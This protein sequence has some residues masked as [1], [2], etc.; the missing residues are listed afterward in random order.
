MNNN[1]ALRP[2]DAEDYGVY[3]CRATN[4]FGSRAYKITVSE[5]LK[6]STAADTFKGDEGEW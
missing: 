3:V 1:I 4:R 2:R 5:G 6:Y